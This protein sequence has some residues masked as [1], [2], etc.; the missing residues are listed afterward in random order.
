MYHGWGRTHMMDRIPRPSTCQTPRPK[1]TFS[2]LRA[3][4]LDWR[5]FSFVGRGFRRERCFADLKS[6]V[7][8]PSA[9]Y[10]ER[11]ATFSEDIDP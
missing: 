6:P 7:R 10:H 9:N 11:I 2:G 5:P 4:V 3:P 1:T 8:V